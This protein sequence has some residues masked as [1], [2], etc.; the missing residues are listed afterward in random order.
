MRC[1]CGERLTRPRDGGILITGRY[2]LV[3]SQGETQEVLVACRACRTVTDVRTRA[4]PTLVRRKEAKDA[5]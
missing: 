4:K 1:T 3:K 2:V 5:D